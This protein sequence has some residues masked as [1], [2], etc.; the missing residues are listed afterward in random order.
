MGSPRACGAMTMTRTLARL[1]VPL[2]F[3]CALCVFWLARPTGPLLAAG[4]IVACFG[5]ALRIWAAGHLSKSREVTASGPY[6]LFAHPLYVG[7]SIMGTGLAIASGSLV[8]ALLIAIYLGVTIAAAIR[9]EEAFLR[10]RFGDGYD[11]YR[12]GATPADA[13]R[14]FSTA[15][16]MANREYR[17]VIGL[18]LAVLLLLAKATYNDSLRRAGNGR[19]RGADAIHARRETSPAGNRCEGG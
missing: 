1:R 8:V 14:R 7:S 16:A 17:A 4:A 5:E 2:G 11:A 10:Q 15:Q 6:R 13:G 12:R 19:L 3:I 18:A 9:S